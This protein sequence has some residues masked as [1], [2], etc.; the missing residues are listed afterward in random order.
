MTFLIAAL[1][2]MLVL[3]FIGIPIF[4]ALGIGAIIILL[5]FMGQPAAFIP[6]LMLDAINSYTLL[7]IPLFLL[8]GE[9]MTRGGVAKYL[10]GCLDK[11]LCHVPGGMAMVTVLACMM[12]AAMSGSSP[13]TAAA[14]A[15]IMLKPMSEL[16][17]DKSFSTGLIACAGTLGILIPPSI[18]MIIYSTITDTSVGKLFIAGVI[19]GI[20]LGILLLIT[21]AFIAW[22]RGYGI[23]PA[24]S[25]GERLKGLQKALPSFTIPAVIFVGI[26]GGV[27]TPTEAAAIACL[28][29]FILGVFV[30]RELK[31]QQ[32]KESF[33]G[34]VR[35]TGI[36]FMIVSTAILFGKVLTISQG[37]QMLINAVTASG[38]PLLGLLALT[39]LIYFALGCVMEIVCLMYVTVPLFFPVLASMGV[40]PVHFGIIVVLNAELAL[41][42]PPIGVNLF[43]VS[44]ASGES[45]GSVVKGAVI[46]YIPLIIALF[47]I[48][49]IPQISLFLPGL[50]R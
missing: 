11:F 16:G 25:W 30:Y 41:V 33:V 32:I 8:A 27:F 20:M 7:A 12:F 15:G 47:L 21:A 28:V 13:A 23:R 42:T 38:I 10:V 48:T 36:I 43:I 2:I 35:M 19:P 17:Y 34:A 45:I 4:I 22:R 50:M 3:L 6:V 46:F 31:W 39:N 14:I 1:I 9:F 29:A 37:P 44:S 24:A 40:N 18:N 5:I 49:Y 26:Y